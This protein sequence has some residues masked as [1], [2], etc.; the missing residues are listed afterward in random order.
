MDFDKILDR[1]LLALAL[2]A[3]FILWSLAFWVAMKILMP[4][5]G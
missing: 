2:P 5:F 3:A 1:L 4:L